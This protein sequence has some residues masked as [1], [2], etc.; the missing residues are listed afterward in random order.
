MGFF[1]EYRDVKELLRSKHSI[2]FYAESRHY[3]QYFDRLIRDLLA[4]GKQIIYLTSDLKDPLL[5]SSF[6]GMKVIYVKYM[7]G[8]LFSRI[9]AAI[10]IMTM[11]DLGNFLF[12]R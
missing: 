11:P 4:S 10:M 1:K 8:T 3:F 6:S 9:K 5:Q 12:K 7:L 2:V